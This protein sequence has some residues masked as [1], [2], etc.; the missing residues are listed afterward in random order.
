VLNFAEVELPMSKRATP[1]VIAMLLATSCLLSI[2]C[3]GSQRDCTVTNLV[4]PASAT[5][6]HT[7]PSPGNVVQFIPIR[8]APS[9]CAIA[10]VMP[11][12]TWTTSDALNTLID[13]NTGKATCIGATPSPATIKFTSSNSSEVFATATLTCR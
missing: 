11:L 8:K 1:A 7:S 6:D 10:T 13:V 3:G 5:A 12:G 4:S 2:G 9:G